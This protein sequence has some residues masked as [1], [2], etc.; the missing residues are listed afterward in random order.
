ME[1]TRFYDDRVSRHGYLPLSLK[2]F[3]YSAYRDGRI[4]DVHLEHL[5]K[6]LLSNARRFEATQNPHVMA[7]IRDV[8]RHSKSRNPLES[9]TGL[10]QA[11]WAL[12]QGDHSGTPLQS[13][14]NR[15]QFRRILAEQWFNDPEHNGRTF[16]KDPMI[17]REKA[18]FDGV[19]LHG[20]SLSHKNRGVLL[21]GDSGIG[22]SYTW[23]NLVFRGHKALADDCA[24]I[25][26]N[27][28]ARLM[29]PPSTHRFR[30]GRKLVSI[31]KRHIEQSGGQPT[32]QEREQYLTQGKN[33][34]GL[35][36]RGSVIPDYSAVP[37]SE[38]QDG[39]PL[40]YV[41]VLKNSTAPHVTIRDMALDDFA[42]HVEKMEYTMFP[43]VFSDHRTRN[44]EEFLAL[45]DAEKRQ[46]GR[47]IAHNLVSRGVRLLHVSVPSTLQAGRGETVAR[48]IDEFLEK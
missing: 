2:Q 14:N 48:H 12:Q 26:F 47:T 29:V 7:E 32:P 41:F 18:K 24:N 3:F 11:L 9:I 5:G 4:K 39:K 6:A 8:I 16:W 10:T 23:A 17:F 20:S 19:E 45:S 44:S 13:S 46:L 42:A 28:E 31:K 27:S 33:P 15:G 22:K 34:L 38:S 37:M 40:R 1:L 36:F 21:M 25:L 30:D 35:R 43:T